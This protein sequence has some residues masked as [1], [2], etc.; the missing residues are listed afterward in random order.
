MGT[1]ATEKFQ[2]IITNAIEALSKSQR[3]STNLYLNMSVY[4]E[5]VLVGPSVQ[6]IR[7]E[8]PSIIVFVDQEPL[9]LFSHKCRYRFYDPRSQKFMYDAAAQFPPYVDRVPKT[10][11]AIHQPV[12]RLVRKPE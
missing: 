8:R 3:C 6:D 7:T 11:V 4:K 12:G 9:G 5:G 1:V 2:K 10:Y